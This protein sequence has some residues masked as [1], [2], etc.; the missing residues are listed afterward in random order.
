LIVDLDKNATPALIADAV[1]KV[2]LGSINS[3]IPRMTF[4][5]LLL[6]RA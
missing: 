3:R 1:L 2:R 4:R 6:K 5:T